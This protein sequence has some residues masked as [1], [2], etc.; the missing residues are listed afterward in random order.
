[1]TQKINRLIEFRSVDTENRTAEFII[2][3]ESVDRHGT[4]FKLSGWDLTSYRKNPIVAYNHRAASDNP[5]DIIGLS[6]VFEE[7]G[8]LI[9]RVTFED[10]NEKAEKVYKKVQNG[11]LR[12]ASVGSII[13]EA[14][15]GNK[16]EGE[17]PDVIYFTRQE[18]VEW[19]IVTAGSNPDAFKRNAE[20][21]EEF[22]KTLKPKEM[23]VKT[24][25]LIDKLKLIQ[26]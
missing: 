22:K 26:L 23:G 7:D 6:E 3:T 20:S 17:D 21:I 10:E 16:S 14:R 25:R 12:M 8:L 9:G 18:L 13:H 11:T 5:D 15:Y 4:S 2:S 19:S 1:M 24:K